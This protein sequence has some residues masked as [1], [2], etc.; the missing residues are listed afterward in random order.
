[1]NNVIMIRVNGTMTKQF[2]DD[3]R[4]KML[5]DIKEGL[6]IVDDTVKDVIVTRMEGLGIEEE[7]KDEKESI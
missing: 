3:F 5:K 6:F 4:Q 2:Y 7:I 1:M